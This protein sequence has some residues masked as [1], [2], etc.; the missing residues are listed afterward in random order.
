MSTFEIIDEYPIKETKQQFAFT[1]NSSITHGN[2][3]TT[4]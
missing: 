1:I 2:Q 3:T 4:K